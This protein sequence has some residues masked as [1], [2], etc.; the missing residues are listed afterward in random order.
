MG[1]GKVALAG[2]ALFLV[3]L[4]SVLVLGSEG[5]ATPVV[6]RQDP[7]LAELETSA[8][9]QGTPASY[10]KLA[11]AYIDRGQPGMAQAVLDQA[12]DL[13]DPAWTLAQSRVSFAQGDLTE[14]VHWSTATT[15]LCK[16]RA[17]ACTDRMSSQATMQASVFQAMQD[18]GI[19]D[20]A[21]ER[22]AASV[23]MSRSGRSVQLAD[24]GL[25]P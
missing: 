3:G 7:T 16:E 13:N 8:A 25:D 19:Q 5:A 9:A 1:L 14:A 18:A 12:A 2:H 6:A 17:G 11:T 20:P 10:A 4:V 21:Q 15:V 22:E 24:S 23:V